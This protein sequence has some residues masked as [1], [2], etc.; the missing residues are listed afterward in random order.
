MSDD[1]AAPPRREGPI[2]L[3]AGKGGPRLGEPDE[4]DAGSV[5]LDIGGDLDLAIA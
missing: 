5:I 2:A 4:H 1:T 3:I